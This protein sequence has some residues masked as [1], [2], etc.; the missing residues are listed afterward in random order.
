LTT[1][2]RTLFTLTTTYKCNEWLDESDKRL[3]ETTN[4]KEIDGKP[5][6]A[7]NPDR[8]KVIGL[9]EYGIP[10]GAYFDEFRTDIHVVEPFPIPVHW[11]RFVTL[12]Y[13]LDMLAALWIAVDERGNAY[14]YKEAY[15]SGLIISEAAQKVREINDGDNIRLHYAPPDLWNRRQESGKSVADWFRE[16]GII[17]FKSNNDRTDGWLSVKEWLKPYETRDME[18][19]MSYFTARLRIFKNC[20]NLI[21][22]L[23]QLKSD[24][25][26]PNVVDAENGTARHEL[27]HSCLTGDTVV[28]TPFGDVPIKDM[29]G[30]CGE[31]FCYDVNSGQKTTSLYRN[32]CITQKNAPILRVT[33]DDGAYVDCTC[34]HP[35][36]TANGWVKAGDL[37][38]E[39]DVIKIS[40]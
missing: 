3:I 13:G 31:V 19:G 10:G 9:G 1:Q 32:V 11:T 20:R 36:L 2:T 33:F 14:V 6:P 21:R 25:K 17:L 18:N 8:Y 4:T 16:Y 12:D 5:N 38:R 30:T 35:F 34:D 24:E 37:S 22:C 28:N 27:T 15:Q 29:V 23:P 7:Y 40:V 26:D 39:D